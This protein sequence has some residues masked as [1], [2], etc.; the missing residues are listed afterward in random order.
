[1]RGMIGQDA[2]RAQLERSIAMGRLAHAMLIAGAAG[3]GKMRLALELAQALNC[4]TGGEPCGD[5]RQCSRIAASKHADVRVIGAPGQAVKIE[6]MRELQQ[7]AAL[8]PFEGR[9]RVFII[10]GAERMTGEAANCLLKT[11]EEPPD[12]VY[13][14]LLTQQPAALLPTV[15]SRCRLVEL[16]PVAA[17][18][19]EAM[20]TEGGADAET[21]RT[22]ARLA[23]GRAGW[24]AEATAD[25]SVLEARRERL[26][27]S[28]AVA[29]MD[30]SARL[31]RAAKIAADYDRARRDVQGANRDASKAANKGESD[32]RQKAEEQARAA[33]KDLEAVL[34]WLGLLRR[35]WRDVLLHKSGRGDLAVN[36]DRSGALAAFSEACS[37]AEAG[38]AVR[39]IT[40]AIDHLGKNANARL[41]LDVLMLRLPQVTAGALQAAAVH[42]G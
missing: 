4:E 10:D 23:E 34:D 12:N 40:D 38:A 5:C 20:L 30:Y 31:V 28:I 9:N 37:V 29:G 22:I 2:L 17:G 3:A 16:R 21:A 6:E 7:D 27:D 36:A 11:L 33:A 18:L 32:K 1:M 26:D 25:P 13:L 15:R 8:V 14:L 41:A 39:D 35:W 19:I 24:A 42:E